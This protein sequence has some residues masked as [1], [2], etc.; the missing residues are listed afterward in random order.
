MRIATTTQDLADLAWSPDSSCFVVWDTLL[1]YKLL[2]YSSSGHCLASFSA[3]QDALG[4]RTVQWSS[5]G[6]MLAVGSYDQVCRSLLT[7]TP[8]YTRD[9]IAASRS[10]LRL[11]C[12]H[13]PLGVAMVITLSRAKQVPGSY[14]QS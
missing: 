14:S 6:R 13:L 1:T 5:D 11:E 8:A 10:V 12:I 2:I 9:R 3:Y 7:V 4:I